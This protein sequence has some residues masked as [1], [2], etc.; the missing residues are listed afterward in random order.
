[1]AIKLPFKITPAHIVAFLSLLLNLLGGTGTVQPLMGG[2]VPD[3]PVASPALPDAATPQ[4]I[5]QN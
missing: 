5:P 2:E 1:M 3:C 4:G